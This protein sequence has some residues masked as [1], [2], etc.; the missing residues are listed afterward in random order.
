[1]Y[2]EKERNM[3]STG[4]V[5]ALCMNGEIS[6]CDQQ[7]Q[8]F[9]L[10]WSIFPEMKKRGTR[11]GNIDRSWIVYWVLDPPLIYTATCLVP[12]TWPSH[13]LHLLIYLIG[14]SPGV[15]FHLHRL[16]GIFDPLVF[17]ALNWRRWSVKSW[18]RKSLH[19]WRLLPRFYATWVQWKH[20]S[21]S[22]QIRTARLII[23]RKNP[24]F[25]KSLCSFTSIFMFRNASP[26]HYPF[27]SQS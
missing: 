16:A 21:H 17:L 6:G 8:T 11:L 22:I 7:P 14:S 2:L 1:M 23:L 13:G 26:I 24:F 27:L 19:I 9:W 18:D 15:V 5:G 20:P 10:F 3:N 4:E 12:G 25:S